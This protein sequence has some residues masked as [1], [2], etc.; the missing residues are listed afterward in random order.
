MAKKKSRTKDEDLRRYYARNSA[1]SEG[2]GGPAVKASFPKPRRLVALRLDEE[3]LEAVR[4]LA[5]RKGL[6]YS[7][8]MRMW[9]TERMRRETA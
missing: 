2:R 6:N 3:T 9:I 5:A 8:L 4:R 1:L 7:T